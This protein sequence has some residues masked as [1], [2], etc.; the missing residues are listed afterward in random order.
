MLLGSLPAHTTTPFT[1]SDNL[2]QRLRHQLERLARQQQTSSYRQLAAAAEIPGPQVIRRLTELLEQ[3]I[4]DDHAAGVD[5]SIAALAISQ[6]VPA[7]PRAGYFMLLRELGIY[8]GSDNG[9]QAAAFHQS[10]VQ[11]VFERYTL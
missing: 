1:M 4:R 8:S 2:K 11:Q 3:I 5:S 6:A 9:N 7:I 10:C